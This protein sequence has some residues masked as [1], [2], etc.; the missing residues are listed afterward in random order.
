MKTTLLI[1]AAV[2][3]LPG[4]SGAATNAPAST[5]ELRWTEAHVRD[6]AQYIALGIAVRNPGTNALARHNYI[7]T[8]YKIYLKFGEEE[9]ERIDHH[10]GEARSTEWDILARMSSRLKAYADAEE[11]ERAVARDAYREGTISESERQRRLIAITQNYQASN[12]ALRAYA[13]TREAAARRL[14]EERCNQPR[15][16]QDVDAEVRR[17]LMVEMERLHADPRENLPGKRVVGK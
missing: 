8:H 16:W 11:L 15:N 2:V 14:A 7:W 17:L 3:L 1:L 4:G 6:V 12:Q 9:Q 13:A 10:L 5:N